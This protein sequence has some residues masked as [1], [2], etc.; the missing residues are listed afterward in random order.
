MGVPNKFVGPDPPSRFPG[1]DGLPNKFPV[2][3]PPNIMDWEE[4]FLLPKELACGVPK[5]EEVEAGWVAEKRGLGEEGTGP[6][7][8]A[9]PLDGVVEDVWRKGEKG[10]DSVHDI[11]MIVRSQLNNHKTQIKGRERRSHDGV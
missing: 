7:S 11:I 4:V 5:R 6:N 8:E 1:D 2:G 10:R 9:E 3:E